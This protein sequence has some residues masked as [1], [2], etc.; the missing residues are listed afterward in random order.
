MTAS[1]TDD[2][3][4]SEAAALAA[5]DA[6]PVAAADAADAEAAEF[7][8]AAQS[9]FDDDEEDFDPFE[10][11]D[12]EIDQ[13]EMDD[14][15]PLDTVD[16][17]TIRNMK[18]I[19][20]RERVFT[21][22]RQGSAREAI[23]QLFSYNPGLRP[24]LLAI[25]NMC[26]E[27]LAASEVESRVEEIVKDNLSVYEPMTMCHMLE[28]AGAL[29]IVVPEP[30]EPAETEEGDAEYLEI[31]EEPDPV[32]TAT[33]VAI[34]IADE[35]AEGREF[36]RIVIEHESV[37]RE[38]YIAVMELADCEEGTKLAAIEQT[39]DTFPIVMKP[40]RFGGHF[41]DMLEK[42]DA[43]A[44]KNRAWHLTE[45][46][47]KMLEQMK[48]ED[49]ADGDDADGSADGEGSDGEGEEK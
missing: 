41:I 42:T 7:E 6:D 36:R 27:G 15:N 34:E 46:G 18:K 28:E 29:T 23:L 49:A 12:L 38:V 37:Y 3:T 33:D 25:I 47:K 14:D 22:K 16:Y 19:K 13:E 48:H 5:D 45:F 31:D 10:T 39:V 2:E 40:R 17:P 43:F 9:I 1:P 21:P 44:W 4:L 24:T 32:V 26:R 11:D 30:P 8:A 20:P 35:Y